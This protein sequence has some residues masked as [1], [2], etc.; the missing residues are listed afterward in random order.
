MEQQTG[1]KSEWTCKRLLEWTS[2]YLK[3]AGVE[4]A[5]LC[6]EI[7]LA[8]VLKRQR[9]ELYTDFNFCPDEGQLGRFRELV[10]RC[11]GHEPAAYLTGKAYFYGLCFAVSPAVLIPRPETELLVAQALDFIARETRR[12]TVEVLDLGTGS[13]CVAIAI[14]ANAVEAEVTAADNSREALEI[15]AKN[16]AAHELQGRIKLVQSDLFEGLEEGGVFDLI[17]GNPPYISDEEYGRLDRGV[18][19][20]E[21]AGA[22][23]GGVDRL[24]V[25][26]K[27]IAQAGAYLAD[28]AAL[29]LEAAWNQGEQVIALFEGSGYLKDVSSV[30][31]NLGHQRV[32]IGRK[33]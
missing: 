29:M 8:D 19:E 3:K 31:D 30:K 4:Q 16:A 5:R 27:I 1:P 32:I 15:A 17:V 24:D 9:I 23:R 21:P 10:R 14:G 20:Y 28:R 11:G 26:R 6:A 25:I 33:K 12:P 7:L 18:R 13:G 2:E 22:L